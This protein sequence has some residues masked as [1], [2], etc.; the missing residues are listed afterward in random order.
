MTK[1]ISELQKGLQSNGDTAIITETLISIQKT[2]NYQYLLFVDE[3]Q[4]SSLFTNIWVFLL[5]AAGS[6]SSAVRVLAYRTTG[7]FL[8]KMNPFFPHLI[9]KTFSDISM[10]ST[11][12]VKSSAI[13]ASSF[14]FIC[15]SLPIHR[16]D[17]F[18]DTTPVF[19]H[20]TVSD[21]IFSEHLASI[22]GSLKRLSIDWMQTLLHSFLEKLATQ[23]DP[24]LYKSLA[25]IVAHYPEPL[26]QDVI[27]FIVNQVDFDALVAKHKEEE[28][29]NHP[30]FAYPTMNEDDEK[31]N[32]KARMLPLLSFIFS[33]VDEL[34]ATCIDLSEIAKLIVEVLNE[35]NE[36][37]PCSQAEIDSSFQLLGLYSNSFSVSFTKQD[38]NKLL[39]TLET[40]VLQKSTNQNATEKQEGIKEDNVNIDSHNT[41]DEKINDGKNE[42]TDSIIAKTGDECKYETKTYSVVLDT[43]KFKDSPSFYLLRLP[44]DFLIP[45]L[46]DG[47]N[48]YGNESILVCSSK[49]KTLGFVVDPETNQ[50]KYLNILSRFIDNKIFDDR[51]ASCYISLSNCINTLKKT[52]QLKVIFSNMV[53]YEANSWYQSMHIV[54]LLYKT[55]ADTV[56][57]LLDERGLDKVISTLLKMCY[58][59]NENVSKEAPKCLNSFLRPQDIEKTMFKITH[60]IDMFEERN[61]LVSINLL[62]Y[63]IKKHR[64]EID[65]DYLRCFVITIS[66]TFPF[67]KGSVPNL[68]SIFNFLSLFDLPSFL[69]KETAKLISLRATYIAGASLEIVTGVVWDK[70][71]MKIRKLVPK[72]ENFLMQ[73]N[74]DIVSGTCLKQETFNSP[75]ASAAKVL[76]VV[77]P[78]DNLT[79]YLVEK[80]AKAIISI[81]PYESAKLLELTWNRIPK[82]EI[83]SFFQRLTT[84]FTYM[85]DLRAVAIWS[86]LLLQNTRKSNISLLS[87]VRESIHNVSFYVLSNYKT[88]PINDDD[89]YIFLRF[90][91]LVNP[92]LSV[93]KKLLFELPHR[94]ISNLV[95]KL[96]E[97]DKRLFDKIIKT[98]EDKKFIQKITAE[99]S[100]LRQQE[101]LENSANSRRRRRS[102]A[103]YFDSPRQKGSSWMT[104]PISSSFIMDRRR[105]SSNYMDIQDSTHSSRRN[106]VTS[107]YHPL[108]A[109]FSLDIIYDTESILKKD[110]TVQHAENDEEE[111][112]DGDFD[113]DDILDSPHIITQMQNNSFVFNQEFLQKLGVFYCLSLN[114]V[115]FKTLVQYCIKNKLHLEYKK[116][117]IPKSFYTYLFD[118]IKENQTDENIEFAKNYILQN[119]NKELTIKYCQMDRDRFFK[120][121]TDLKS[122]QLRK[123][124]IKLIMYTID[125]IKVRQDELFEFAVGC[126]QSSYSAK[127]FSTGLMLCNLICNQFAFISSDW[128]ENVFMK[129]EEWISERQQKQVQHED[130][131][132]FDDNEE[133]KQ[134]PSILIARFLYLSLQK[135]SLP[136][137]RLE[138]LKNVIIPA[139]YPKSREMFYVYESLMSMEPNSKIMEK[140]YTIAEEFIQYPNPVVYMCGVYLFISSLAF[141]PEKKIEGII[142]SMLI[143]TL[144]LYYDTFN[145]LPFIEECIYSLSEYLLLN[146]EQILNKRALMKQYD[147]IIGDSS[148]PT[149]QTVDG[150][151]PLMIQY[152]EPHSEVLQKIV[153]C[154]K[155]L[156]TSPGSLELIKTLLMIVKQQ[157][158]RQ[159]KNN[160]ETGIE[161]VKILLKHIVEFDGTE[162]VDILLYIMNYV[163]E[164]L[165]LIEGFKFICAN[166]YNSI[167]RFITFF[168]ALVIF[169]KDKKED[170]KEFEAQYKQILQTLVDAIDNECFKKAIHALIDDKKLSDEDYKHFIEIS[171]FPHNPEPKE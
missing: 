16:L 171:N 14:A 45:S 91:I 98:D 58:D 69:D 109:I 57:I 52:E 133:E 100:E 121:F 107:M 90:E 76:S 65:M 12:D 53:F 48:S 142:K 136:P 97:K 93:V 126:L 32:R 23:N 9:Q 74:F 135:T 80:F 61:F 139:C 151:L 86:R 20:F 146:P 112:C 11:I 56:E 4:I 62:T 123:K 158:I 59:P 150:L 27:D 15:N 108:P 44:F 73:Q 84:K 153:E 72:V 170:G 17:H 83:V 106:S 41:E 132:E 39:L 77:P 141:V 92:D 3:D 138:F 5:H 63:L 28:M 85:K 127:K 89:F 70:Q 47:S 124:Y 1:F 130:D 164:I 152:A 160:P 154:K 169:I 165:D 159:N 101:L 163:V 110:F 155:T 104:A 49:I 60:I 38:N 68:T 24:F 33:T 81:F 143:P 7:L 122:K 129:I 96:Y 128:C 54:K 125:Q 168:N 35:N 51:L 26:I 64:N 115:G 13:L 87:G 113:E 134:L 79:E 67:F 19:H 144:K 147:W 114:E 102:S 111:A 166:F 31:Y 94:K 162:I 118:Y 117:N 18:L 120:E 116:F 119:E 140:L 36:G 88:Y 10:Q 29:K 46:P 95:S 75:L 30:D 131:S 157:L 2:I 66:E 167:P 6:N 34:D 156:F 71:N 99:E 22:I 161:K 103:I 37:I 40:K 55:K 145:T 43:E 82:T 42:E 137:S 21:P 78:Q 25:A 148:S 149:F 105:S 8:L 50:D